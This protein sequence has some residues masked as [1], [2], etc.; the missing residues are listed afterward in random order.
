MNFLFL[1]FIAF[2]IVAIGNELKVANPKQQGL[3]HRRQEPTTILESHNSHKKKLDSNLRNCR[4]DCF[5]IIVIVQ[6]RALRLLRHRLEPTPR[7][8][9]S[10]HDNTHDIFLYY[11]YQNILYHYLIGLCTF[12]HDRYPFRHPT[13]YNIRILISHQRWNA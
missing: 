6:G 12:H 13:F 10:H 11:R 8:G 4:V 3:L 5:L 9:D 1:S 2:R 7:K